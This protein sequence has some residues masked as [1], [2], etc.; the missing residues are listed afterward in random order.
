MLKSFVFL[1]MFIIHLKLI[2]FLH[3]FVVLSVILDVN[4][5]I[6]K[7]MKTPNFTL[8]SILDEHLAVF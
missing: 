5:L 4:I 1:S 3:L 6:L 8:I 7:F 2:I